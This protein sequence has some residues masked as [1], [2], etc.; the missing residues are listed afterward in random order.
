MI[1][2]GSFGDIQ[3]RGVTVRIESGTGTDLKVIG[4][5]EGGLYFSTDPVETTHAYND[6]FD[7]L[8]RE[9]CTIRLLSAEPLSQLYS[10]DVLENKVT[11]T[12]GTDV[13][14]MGYVEPQAFSQPF[15]SRLDEVELSCID[16]LSAMQYLVWEDVSRDDVD[17]GAKKAAATQ[18]SAGAI[19]EKCLDRVWPGIAT[20]TYGPTVTVGNGNLSALHGMYIDTVIFFGD[21]E[22]SAWTLLDVVESILQYLNLRMCVYQGDVRTY[23]PDKL[24]TKK[25]IAI[26][27]AKAWDKSHQM[28]VTETYNKLL[29]TVERDTVDNVVRNPLDEDSLEKVYSGS[30]IWCTEYSGYTGADMFNAMGLMKTDT[31]YAP[32]SGKRKDHYLRVLNAPGWKF[33]GL[34]PPGRTSHLADYMEHYCDPSSTPQHKGANLLQPN[35]GAMLM[36]I[37]TGAQEWGY[38]DNAVSNSADTSQYLVIG[39]D[40]QTS[41]IDNDTEAIATAISTKLKNAMPVAEYTGGA[42]DLSPVDEETTRYIVF[43]GK[44]RLNPVHTPAATIAKM[45]SDSKAC[46]EAL[47]LVLQEK[48][49]GS[50]TT[51]EKAGVNATIAYMDS[52]PVSDGYALDKYITSSTGADMSFVR[53]WWNDRGKLMMLSYDG[54]Y[55]N[56]IPAEDYDTTE[57]E[58]DKTYGVEGKRF[59]CR[60]YWECATPDA[61]PV[62]SDSTAVTYGLYPPEDDDF[63]NL[64]EYA[65]SKGGGHSG[66]SIDR[67]SELPVLQCMLIVGNKCVVQTYQDDMSDNSMDRYEWRVYKTR[68]Q[69]SSDDEYYAQSFTLG[70][71]I[72]IGDKIIGPEYDIANNI[73]YTLGVDGKGTA[74]PVRK[75]DHVTGTVKFMILGPYNAMWKDIVRIPPNFYAHTQWFANSVV[76]LNH[77]SAIWIKDFEVSVKTKGSDDAED[78]DLIYSSDTDETFINKKDD[79]TFRLASALTSTERKALAVPDAVCRNTPI[80]SVTGAGVTAVRDLVRGVNGKPER[81]YLDWHWNKAHRARLT[82]IHGVKDVDDNVDRFNLYTHPALPDKEFFVDGISRNLKNGSAQIRIT[83]K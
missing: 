45:K 48:L 10:R 73:S 8:M 26:D 11:V 19:I 46:F 68:E 79:L 63:F 32:A 25:S 20:S 24:G 4:E 40:G 70:I 30:Q 51:G 13:I 71:D 39:V 34:L 33:G 15:N 27:R 80:D 53:S 61:T 83:E 66:Q 18:M 31:N 5:Q 44:M 64:L 67:I 23:H 77:V 69:C 59:Y 60:R 17:Y 74:I 7:V 37:R 81:L 56:G 16:V 28:E 35:M 2:Q 43:S 50:L 3:G 57:E 52:L 21:D 14:F 38:E 47:K 62:C 65:Y 22:D 54:A 1:Y 12:R 41:D 82:L 49:K 42:V 78:G 6:Q 9:S 75:S 36:E 72:K 55:M 58:A 76:I 29:L